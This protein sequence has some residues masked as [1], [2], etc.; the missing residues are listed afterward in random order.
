[1]ARRIFAEYV[2]R[3]FG[4]LNH[5]TELELSDSHTPG[6]WMIHILQHVRARMSA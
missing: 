5:E 1:M 6:F 2:Q 4:G 3:T